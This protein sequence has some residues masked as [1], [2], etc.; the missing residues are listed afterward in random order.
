MKSALAKRLLLAWIST[1]FAGMLCAAGAAERCIVIDPGHGGARDVDESSANNATSPSGVKEKDLTLEVS[2]EVFQAI[3]SSAEAKKLG[4]VPVITRTTDV[5][6]GM[7]ERARIA[8]ARNTKAFVSIHFNAS[9]GH[10]AQGALGMVQDAGHGNPNVARDGA[11]ANALADAVSAV[12]QRHDPKSRRRGY[13]TDHEL[14][15]GRGSFL[16]HHLRETAQG[17]SFPACFLEIDF[18]DNPAVEAW[19]VNGAE[20]K[21]VRAEI[22]KA[23]ANALIKYVAAN[24]G[25]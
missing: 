20:G 10:R 2:R 5:N 6:V 17:R 22:A 18:I 14:K 8:L 16:L 13:L 23:L 3:E 1:V 21:A 12:A 19:L 7:T 11:Y 4:I 9:E 15:G 24:G 25:E